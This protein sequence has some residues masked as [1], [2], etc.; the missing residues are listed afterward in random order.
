[1]NLSKDND[2]QF[3][4]FCVVLLRSSLILSKSQ[5]LQIFAIGGATVSFMI[6]ENLLSHAHLSGNKTSVKCL[7]SEIWPKF[8]S[9]NFKRTSADKVSV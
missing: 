8:T 3:A 9:E 1:M 7:L 2:K 5:V 6:Q 4:K